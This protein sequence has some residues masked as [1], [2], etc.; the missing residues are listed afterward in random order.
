[1]SLAA[2]AN[3]VIIF[4]AFLVCIPALTNPT[5]R[6]WLKLHAYAV[7]LSA[8]FTL[9]LGLE[10]WFQTLNTGANLATLWAQQTIENQ[11]LLQ[12]RFLCCGYRNATT[13]PFIPDNICTNSLVAA[14]LQG[15]VGPFSQFA[16]SLLSLVFTADFGIVAIDAM[17]LL[18]TAC[19]LKDRKE[20]ARYKLIDAKTGFAPI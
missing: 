14:N 8:V 15:C 1:M 2:I 19:L 10:I 17:L 3:A 18:S 16:N 20:K 4:L 12:Q 5:N 7:T 13:P 11:S 9:V 6:L